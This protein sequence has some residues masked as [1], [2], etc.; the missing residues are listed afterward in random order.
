MTSPF[1]RYLRYSS[2]VNHGQSSPFRT[3][4]DSARTEFV[5]SDI[6][7]SS[8][9][10]PKSSLLKIANYPCDPIGHIKVISLNSPQKY[11]ALSRQ[12]VSELSQEFSALN[13]AG[14][15]S[16]GGTR[17]LILES[18]LDKYFCVGADLRER[19]KMSDD[20]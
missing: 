18:S 6:A 10:R 14:D 13:E 11:N 15:G 2:T 3:N 19:R 20:Q 16:H 12:L 1:W 17:A 5:L 4:G 7:S 9:S 8:E